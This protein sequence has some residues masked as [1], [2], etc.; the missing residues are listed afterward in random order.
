MKSLAMRQ[1]GKGKTCTAM[2]AAFWASDLVSS[3]D[4]TLWPKVGQYFRHWLETLPLRL[5]N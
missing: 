1:A 4:L 5:E 3:K 2:V